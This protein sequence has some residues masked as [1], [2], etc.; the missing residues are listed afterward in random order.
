MLK[1][2]LQIALTC[3]FMTGSVKTEDTNQSYFKQLWKS[4]AQKIDT[5]ARHGDEQHKA[6]FG[7]CSLM[8]AAT[9]LKLW[10]DRNRM[11]E[12]FL[13]DP[14][15]HI[16]SN[17]DELWTWAQKIKENGGEIVK[18]VIGARVNNNQFISNTGESFTH[19]ITTKLEPYS[20]T[21]EYKTVLGIAG[22]TALV[23]LYSAYKLLTT[24]EKPAEVT[25]EN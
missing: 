22:V 4:V 25:Q 9:G 16:V 20:S 8:S 15:G 19:I 2:C 23:A 24:P 14:N 5:I 11:V 12:C 17:F 1:K 3:A 7:V 6:I 13:R 18:I 21:I 10:L